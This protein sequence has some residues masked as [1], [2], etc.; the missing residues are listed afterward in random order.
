EVP[1]I[2][3]RST[4]CSLVIARS[5][6][7][8]RHGYF[9]LGTNA[10][11][12]ASLIGRAPFFLEVSRHMPRTFGENQLHGSQVFGWCQSDSSLRE[13]PPAEPDPVDESIGQFVAERVP[14]G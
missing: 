10:D 9:S 4:K 14:N 13:V 2:L 1:S 5:A 7:P 3:R 8:D 6:P 12:T 11:Y